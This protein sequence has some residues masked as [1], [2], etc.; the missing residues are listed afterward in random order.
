MLQ[1]D[2][3]DTIRHAE[4]AI[5]IAELAGAE[6]PRIYALRLKDM[7]LCVLG[8]FDEGIAIVD[9]SSELALAKGFHNVAWASLANG[10]VM[11][12]PALRMNEVPARLDLLRKVSGGL[13][14]GIVSINEAIL[15]T[16]LGMMETGL[17]TLDRVLPVAIETGSE[18]LVR[19]AQIQAGH[20]LTEL[21]RLAE[22]ERRLPAVGDL[23]EATDKIYAGPMLMRLAIVMGKPESAREAAEVAFGHDL[24]PNLVQG[25]ANA[26]V[27]LFLAAGDLAAARRAAEIAMDEHAFPA[28]LAMQPATVAR[29]AL[30][31]G[32]PAAAIAPLR[33]SIELLRSRAC[34]FGASRQRQVLA[35][36]LVATG[37]VEGAIAELREVVAEGERLGMRLEARLARERLAKLGATA[38]PALAAVPNP[39]AASSTGEKLVTVLFAD[40]R[41]YTAITRS[42][43]P[44]EMAE[45]I[46]TFQR[47]AS[48]EIGRHRGLVDKFAG[49]AVMATFNVSG[50]SVDH[51]RYALECAIA[52]RDKA[53]LLGL[54]LGV[55][56]ATGPAIV[57]TLAPGANVS[58]V[59]EATNLASRLQSQAE[60]GE[61]VLSAEAHRRLRGW[62]AEQALGSRRVELTL[63]GFAEPVT[64]HRLT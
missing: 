9:Q 27:E 61:I 20:C 59:G 2:G 63:K 40:V 24:G 32:N 29:L 13:H 31:D 17:E 12:D 43:V 16:S 5:R 44:A 8:R 64:A 45:Q 10:I 52:L 42:A 30:V 55:G 37:D 54:P 46:A 57:G 60:A 56:I 39:E 47:W 48:D 33:A 34:T 51:A 25:Y 49:D 6:M 7:G 41:G 14:Q 1:Q 21:D 26:S 22:A 3:E 50:A 19:R 23:P 11:R 28:A 4:A 62:L 18:A 53:A 58:V 38:V 36:L 15:A 35:D